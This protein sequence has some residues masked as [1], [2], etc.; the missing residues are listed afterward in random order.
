MQTIQLIKISQTTLKIV[1]E[2]FQ[3][4]E[5]RRSNV[6]SKIF[7]KKILAFVKI[8]E[9]AKNLFIF[10]VLSNFLLS[11]IVKLSL[12]VKINIMYT[13]KT[14]KTIFVNANVVDESIF[15]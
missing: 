15:D 5:N 9:F 3:L 14:Q 11:S 12:I 2:I 8:F 13:R 7:K 1:F 4:F 10:I 6:R